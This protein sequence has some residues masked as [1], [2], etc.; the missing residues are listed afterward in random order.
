MLENGL[1]LCN[2]ENACILS[3]RW[4]E[5]VMGEGEEVVAGGRVRGA[6]LGG[7]AA[8]YLVHGPQKLLPVGRE[9]GLEGVRCV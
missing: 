8:G 4:R 2:Q 3:K 9:G 6:P 7:P 5:E 1:L